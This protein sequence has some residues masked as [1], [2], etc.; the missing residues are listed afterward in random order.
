M[1]NQSSAYDTGK[2]IAPPLNLYLREASAQAELDS[3]RGLNA[4]RAARRAGEERFTNETLVTLARVCAS[5]GAEDAVWD[6]LEMLTERVAGRI[7]RHLQVW[8]VTQREAREDLCGEILTA[9]YDCIACREVSQEFWE[10]RFWI[11]FDRRARTILRDYRASGS[12][13]AGLDAQPE[14]LDIGA[15]AVDDQVIARSALAALPE[16]LR[17]AFVLKHYAGY[18]EE[19]S[20][21]EEYTIASTL[22][23]SGRTV[24]NYLR[25]AQDL[26]APW[27][28]RE[29]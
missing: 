26:L 10:C 14:A 27:R 25:R 2:P 29:N 28:E 12:E 8:G 17:T 11:C 15:L 22:G 23:V 21:P 18:A 1:S 5:E 3:L 7:A 20:N 19:S 13:H 6:L 16:P 24:R 4:V 9:M